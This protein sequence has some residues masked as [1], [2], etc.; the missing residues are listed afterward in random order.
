VDFGIQRPLTEVKLYFLDDET[1]PVVE[2]VGEEEDSGFPWRAARAGPRSVPPDSF[3][4]ERW[5]GVEWVEVTGQVREPKYPA[6][7]RANAV[8]FPEVRTDRV[9]V[10]LF[11][12]EGATVG[13][14][15]LEAWGPG[16]LPLPEPTAPDPNL[17]LNP[18]REGYP[19]V[20]ASFTYEGDTPWEAVDGRLSLTRYARNRW[21]AYGTPHPEDWLAVEFGGEV[22]V[23][24]VELFFY[25]D[26]RGVGAP[27]DYRVEVWNDGAWEVAPPLT[28]RPETPLAWALN[29]VLLAPV[30]TS[31]IRVVLKHAHPLASG[32]AEVRVF[33]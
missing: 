28:R 18:D 13:L 16:E 27:A 15:E 14:T 31:R 10:V 32:V 1:V 33:R 4:L 21:T 7:R 19:R 9:R 12:R 23:G 22:E 6:G 26:G 3:S 25:G 24:R 30:R 5:T 11:L 8:R 29:R 2:A 20:S 17:A